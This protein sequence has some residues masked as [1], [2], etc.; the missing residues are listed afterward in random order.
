M[1]APSFSPRRGAP[2]RWPARARHLAKRLFHSAYWSL[3][4]Y[5]WVWI[6]PAPRA[7][8]VVPLHGPPRGHPERLCEDR[9]LSAVEQALERQ[10]REA[11]G[12]ATGNTAN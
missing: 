9:P 3:S 7:G 2:A 4:D 1:T 10:L 12:S 8:H 11:L 5:G 6:G